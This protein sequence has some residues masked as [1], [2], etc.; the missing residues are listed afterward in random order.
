MNQKII[1]EVVPW[2]DT[3]LSRGWTVDNRK[4]ILNICKTTDLAKKIPNSDDYCVCILEKIQK[5]YRFQEYQSLLA[6]EKTIII[7]DFGALCYKETGNLSSV[8]ES[9]RNQIATLFQQEQYGLVIEKSLALIN[10]GQATALDFNTIGN[11]Y[12]LTKQYGKSNKYLK[13][14]EKHD[15]T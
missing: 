10:A 6:I 11:S 9:L 2:V 1:L 3:M 12:L 7:T 4:S 13:E 14:G 15:D 5:E 8:S